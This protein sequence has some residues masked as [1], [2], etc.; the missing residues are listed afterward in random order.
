[1]ALVQIPS[2]VFSTATSSLATASTASTTFTPASCSVT[3]ITGTTALV[4]VSSKVTTANSS[5]FGLASFAVS[6]ASTVTAVDSNAVQGGGN[7]AT[8]NAFHRGSATTLLTNLT[9]GS[10]T[11]TVNI[12]STNG[13][14]TA[15]LN[16]MQISVINMSS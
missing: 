14:V 11:F 1:M 12:R 13:S 6:G 8:T 10:N 9:P 2:K 15:N 5:H 4:T 7:A 16:E 3:L